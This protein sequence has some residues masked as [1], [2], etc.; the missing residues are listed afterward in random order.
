ML[1]MESVIGDITSTIR[2]LRP[3]LKEP[4]LLTEEVARWVGKWVRKRV[5]KK[6]VFF[7]VWR[8]RHIARYSSSFPGQNS[9]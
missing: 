1:G 8:I 2:S 9:N 7:L 5:G 4:L 3:Q 6:E